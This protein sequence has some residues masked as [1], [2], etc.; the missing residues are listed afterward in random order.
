MKSFAILCL[1]AAA[2]A[3]P[4][5]AS[6]PK[7]LPSGKPGIA[8]ASNCTGIQTQLTQGIQANLDI[9]AQELAG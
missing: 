2:L 7:S 3:A 6:N 9:Q 8:A 1:V 4:S 5:P